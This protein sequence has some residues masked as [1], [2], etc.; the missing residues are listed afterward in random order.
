MWKRSL[1]VLKDRVRAL[2]G[3][4]AVW[5]IRVEGEHKR[6]EDVRFARFGSFQTLT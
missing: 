5:K 3:E 4:C 2:E 6:A 1:D